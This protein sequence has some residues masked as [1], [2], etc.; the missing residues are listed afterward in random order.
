MA[1]LR[2]AAGLALRR[3]SSPPDAAVS[4]FLD[5]AGCGTPVAGLPL[6]RRPAPPTVAATAAASHFSATAAGLDPTTPTPRYV[7]LPRMDSLIPDI[8]QLIAKLESDVE[9]KN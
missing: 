4:R 8:T 7:F 9:R 6:L 2:Y 5:S 1:M 3:S